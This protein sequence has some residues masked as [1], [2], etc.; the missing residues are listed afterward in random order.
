MRR[1]AGKQEQ[2]GGAGGGTASP[3]WEPT[4]PWSKDRPPVPLKNTCEFDLICVPA[5]WSVWKCS[6][7]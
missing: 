7:V 5:Q 6:E 1:V 2:A 3:G 4:S